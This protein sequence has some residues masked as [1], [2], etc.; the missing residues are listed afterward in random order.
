MLLRE[1]LVDPLL[2]RYSVI[3]LDEA[4]ERTL[5]TDVLFGVVKDVQAG[6]PALR[7]RAWLLRCTHANMRAP[8]ARGAC[9][10][11]G[12]RAGALLTCPRWPRCAR[13]LLR[14]CS[15]SFRRRHA[16]GRAAG[17][18]L[19]WLL[20]GLH[21]CCSLARVMQGGCR[22]HLPG[23]PTRHLRHRQRSGASL[24][25]VSAQA[26][27][28]S[29]LRLVA[30]SATLDAAKFVTYFPGA[31]AAYL[32]AR[33]LLWPPA[34]VSRRLRRPT[35][36][37]FRACACPASPGQDGAAPPRTSRAPAPC[38][39]TCEQGAG[40]PHENGSAGPD[41][42]LAE[43]RRFCHSGG[44]PRRA[45][46]AARRPACAR[47]GGSSPCRSSTR[48]RRRRATWTRRCR[49]SCRRAR[50]RSR[51]PCL[52]GLQPPVRAHTTA[53]AV[54]RSARCTL[55]SALRISAPLPLCRP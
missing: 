5:Q 22:R 37:H 52:L 15:Y 32:Q 11:A 9:A 10:V 24:A 26:R 12:T 43:R 28:A 1:A 16:A 49:P 39:R 53:T 42:H 8:E 51:A 50:A 23:R 19:A 31:K 44:S 55:R 3:V 7:R 14:G 6:R 13:P 27:R 34:P 18:S 17:M 41:A 48:P 46:R 21:G 40:A 30:M 33:P 38:E 20:S 54:A 29:D 2:R 25:A 47:R 36:C 35:C 45:S 4:H